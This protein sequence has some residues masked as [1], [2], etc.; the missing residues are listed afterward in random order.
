MNVLPPT[1][2]LVYG[3]GT[4]TV[5]VVTDA[6]GNDSVLPTVNFQLYQSAVSAASYTT[7]RQAGWG[8]KPKGDNAGALLAKYFDFLYP[9]DLTIGGTF[10]IVQTSALAVQD[11]LP[12]EGRPVPL[13]ADYVDP[14][15]KPLGLL[16][17]RNMQ[18]ELP[19]RVTVPGQVALVSVD[20]HVPLREDVF[21]G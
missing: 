7:F 12:Q 18:K 10:T 16:V 19:D 9:N 4:Q 15:S 21:R 6:N 20:V 3:L 2:Y 8:T 13:K 1:G 14:L 11:L 17:L 5:T